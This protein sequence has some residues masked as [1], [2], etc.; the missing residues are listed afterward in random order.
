[1][2]KINLLDVLTPAIIDETL[3]LK[4]YTNISDL[5]NINYETR[6]SPSIDIRYPSCLFF[7]SKITSSPVK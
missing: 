7:P 2:M 3:Q 6:G 5:Y 1:M 4:K